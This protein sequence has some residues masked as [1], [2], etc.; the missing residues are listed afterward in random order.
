MKFINSST[1]CVV[2]VNTNNLSI[3]HSPLTISTTLVSTPKINMVN[4]HMRQIPK[5][6]C[7]MENGL[8]SK[9]RKFHQNREKPTKIGKVHIK[10][11]SRLNLKCTSCKWKN[12]HGLES[13]NP[14]YFP[15][16]VTWRFP[17]T[18]S[19]PWALLLCHN[20]L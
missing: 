8:I 13:L 14:K 7:I 2:F 15:I 12:N 1:T 6:R 11:K 19:P 3:H 10:M 20:S 9:V 18:S 4:L 5:I 17:V 16:H